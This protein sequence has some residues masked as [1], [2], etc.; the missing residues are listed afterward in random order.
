MKEIVGFFI[1]AG[2]M[3]FPLWISLVIHLVEK[4]RSNHK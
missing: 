1:V 2:L 3:G 4:I